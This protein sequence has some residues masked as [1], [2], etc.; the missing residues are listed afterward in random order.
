MNYLYLYGDTYATLNALKL[1]FNSVGFYFL[2][3]PYKWDQ[4]VVIT[5][6]TGFI[7]IFPDHIL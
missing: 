4:F 6:A 2:L 7:M 1:I 5:N 3:I